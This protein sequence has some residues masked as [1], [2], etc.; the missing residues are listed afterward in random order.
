[1]STRLPYLLIILSAILTLTSIGAQASDVASSPTALLDVAQRRVQLQQ[2]EYSKA[3]TACM[4]V[5]IDAQQLESLTPISALHPTSGY[6]TDNS[7]EDFSWAVMVLSGRA[8]AG[9]TVS[10]KRLQDVLLRYAKAKAFMQTKAH[11]DP[12]Y[13]LKRAML[14]VIV[15]YTIVAPTM[16]ES[17]RAAVYHWIDAV[18]RPL[19]TRFGGDVD[20]NNHRDLADATLMA[21]GSVVD[22][23][24]L[25]QQGIARFQT[26]LSHAQADGG[27]PLETR[28]GARAAWYMRQSL[29]NL[30]VMAQ[31]A[32]LHSDDNLLDKNM[33]GIT[34]HHLV[35]YT[36]SVIHN[37]LYDIEK[38]LYNYIPGQNFNPYQLDK[39]MLSTRPNQRHYMA[40]AELY[41]LLA[42]QSDDA[43]TRFQGKR[44]LALLAKL[45]N[46]R[47]LIDEYIGGNA[48][49]FWWH[50]AQ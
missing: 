34:Y 44:M 16:Q 37:P 35:D 2:A 25:I 33:N 41:A 13:A 43:F 11:H 47:P 29:A 3:R 21:W 4:A 14:P 22:D 27:L 20:H 8:L 9:D 31:I 5:E 50:P 17:D 7:A 6:G 10:E 36:L 28:R 40:F 1:M 26:V 30:L 19:D 18:V 45:H 12:Y 15:G 23:S 39:G 49:C 48:T 24:A 38:R 46:E 32:Q 42:I